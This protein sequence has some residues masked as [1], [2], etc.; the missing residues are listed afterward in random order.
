MRPVQDK[1]AG[2]PANAREIAME[3]LTK[4]EQEKAYS[5]L[6]LNQALHKHRMERADASLATEITYGTIQRLNTIDYY[7]NRF[8]TKGLE[9]LQPW[10]RSLLRLSFYQLYY[11]DRVPAHAVVNEAVMIAKRKGHQGIAGMVNGVLRNVLRQRQQLVL[12]D[13]LSTAQKIALIHSHPEWMVAR[14]MRQYGTETA[15]AICEANN[16]SPCVSVRVNTMKH[17][18]DEMICMMGE[19]GVHARKSELAPAGLIVESGGNLALST[20]YADGDLSIQDESSMLVA[21]AVDAQPGMKVLDCCAAPGGKTAHMAEKMRN[22][23]IVWAVDLYEHKEKLIRDQAHRLALSCIETMVADAGHLSDRF[24]K[25]YFDRILLDA[26]CS[27]LGVIRR[28]PDIKWTKRESEIEQIAEVQY[29]LLSKI[30]CLLRPGGVLVYSTCTIET[31]ENQGV[32]D[33]FLSTHASFVLDPAMRGLLPDKLAAS[34]TERP[35]MR[36]IL[37]H[38][39]HSDGFFIAR[40]LKE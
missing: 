31:K 24:P 8:V 23:G 29:E 5:N 39:F 30:H 10:V 27:G 32:I 13:S 4:V 33:R 21:E 7:L 35:G 14:W 19:H 16:S 20:W 3:I 6:L 34:N 22:Q 1:K 11:L 25:G 37:P 15:A 40:L 17:D 18:R 28:K 9:K 36:Q 38:Q 12:P 26:P 2:K